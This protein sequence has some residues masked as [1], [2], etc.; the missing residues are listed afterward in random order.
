MLVL[1]VHPGWSGVLELSFSH[2]MVC[3]FLS[4]LIKPT[5]VGLVGIIRL[6]F[7]GDNMLDK[8]TY[9]LIYSLIRSQDRIAEA[10]E[11]IS[12]TLEQIKDR[13]GHPGNPAKTDQSKE[14]I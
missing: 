14:T 8:N 12:L 13:Q 3:V 6:I 9:D 4:D 10:L 1:V 2:L 11:S 7:N 5:T